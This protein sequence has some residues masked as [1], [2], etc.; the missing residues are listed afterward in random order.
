MG[1][2]AEVEERL[3]QLRAATEDLTFPSESDEPVEVVVVEEPYP[4]DEARRYQDPVEEQLA[5]ELVSMLSRTQDAARWHAVYLLLCSLT[6]LRVYR[7]GAGKSVA[8]EVYIVGQ[9]D[10][11]MLGLRTVSIET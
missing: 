11:V 10:G 1:R 2:T 3:S 8:V 6:G 9:M 4:W 7:I 5:Q